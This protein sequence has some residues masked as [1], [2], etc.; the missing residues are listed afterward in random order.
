MYS[1]YYVIE[2][3]HK[4]PEAQKRRVERLE[5]VVKKNGLELH[6][7]VIQDTVTLQIEIDDK[8]KAFVFKLAAE[9]A[10]HCDHS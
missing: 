8:K 1:F 6:K 5:Q 3:D 9:S 2:K 7:E 4:N 10:L